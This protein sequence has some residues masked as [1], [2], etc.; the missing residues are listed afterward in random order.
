MVT[1]YVTI[2][3]EVISRTAGFS[4]YHFHR[5]FKAMVEKTINEYVRRL[6]L[7][8]AAILLGHNPFRSITE[9][10]L[11][12]GFSSSSNF[13][14]AFKEHFGMSASRWREGRYHEYP[15]GK[16]RQG[17]SKPGEHVSKNEKDSPL[18][19]GYYSTVE[20]LT[21]KESQMKVEIKQMLEIHIVYVRHMK[22]YWDSQGLR[23]T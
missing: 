19:T 4:Q 2:Y 20:P 14:R 6:R 18:D 8:R 15:L 13:P 10:A 22:G 1:Q 12:C 11:D 17:V 23:E 16:I 21:V 5:I 9:I 7:E 3:R